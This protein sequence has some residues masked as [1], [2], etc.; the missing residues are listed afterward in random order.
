M[1]W[2]LKSAINWSAIFIAM[3]MYFHTQR[4]NGLYTLMNSKT[5]VVCIFNKFV[6]YQNVLLCFF[7]DNIIGCMQKHVCIAWISNYIPQYFVAIIT[8]SCLQYQVQDFCIQCYILWQTQHTAQLCTI[9]FITPIIIQDRSI[10]IWYTDFGNH[11][12]TH[13][14]S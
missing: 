7:S 9:K 1:F 6:D 10:I 5:F 4:C 11:I 3:K 12:D 14:T 13:L 8:Y 2:R